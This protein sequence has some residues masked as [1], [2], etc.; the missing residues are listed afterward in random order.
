MSQTSRPWLVYGH[1]SDIDKSVHTPADLGRFIYTVT[2]QLTL[3]GLWTKKMRFFGS[4]SEVK[5]VLITLS[6]RDGI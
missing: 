3:A 1:F 5:K 6:I 4:Q 2:D